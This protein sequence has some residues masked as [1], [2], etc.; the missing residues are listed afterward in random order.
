M[1]RLIFQDS[2]IDF[3]YTGKMGKFHRLRQIGI[4]GTYTYL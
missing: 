1:S 2:E 3:M 4:I